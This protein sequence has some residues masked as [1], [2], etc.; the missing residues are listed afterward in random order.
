M[1]DGRDTLRPVCRS[2]RC[3]RC[4]CRGGG[5]SRNGGVLAG[6]GGAVGLEVGRQPLPPVFAQV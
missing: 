6:V 4:G 5:R 2:C 3:G 1:G